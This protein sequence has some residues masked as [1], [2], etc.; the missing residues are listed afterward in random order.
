M[1]IDITQTA[2]GASG[3]KDEAMTRETSANT[4]EAPSEAAAPPTGTA[5][6]LGMRDRLL[7]LWIFLAMAAGILLGAV[8]PGV[9]EIGRAHV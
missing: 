9:S 7:T 2:P 6:R 3:R 1:I 4:A 5:V 8:V